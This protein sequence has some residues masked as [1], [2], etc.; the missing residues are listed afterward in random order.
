MK[1]KILILGNLNEA[2][3]DKEKSIINRVALLSSISANKREYT[4]GCLAGSVSLLEG[5]KCYADHDLSGKT[6]GV[7]DLIGIYRGVV[8]EGKKVFG[9]LHLL[10][11][12]GEMSKRMLAIVEQMPEIVGNSISARGR[13]HVTDG[14][15]IVEE[16]TK[17]NSVDIVTNPATTSSLFESIE[18]IKEEEENNMDLKNLQKDELKTARPD[19]YAKIVQE[20]ADSRNKEVKD[21]KEA[22]DLFEV[23]EKIT[24]KK[25]KVVE[26]LKEEKIAEDLVTEIFMETLVAVPN[27][28]EKLHEETIKKLIADRKK[29]GK[30]TGGVKDYGEA[31]EEKENKDDKGKSDEDKNKDLAEAMTQ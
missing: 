19:L 29:V 30:S 12:G 4:E 1:V 22:N 20:G 9:N 24:K 8:H 21:L 5:A 18:P 16:L 28:D 7:R 11:D 26:I 15:D 3:I 31:K 14:K 23:K 6:R 25:E 17:V 13:Y 2:S 10:N 27:T